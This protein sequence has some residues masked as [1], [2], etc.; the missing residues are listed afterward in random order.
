MK[1]ALIAGLAGVAVLAAASCSSESADPAPSGPA[2]VA[3]PAILQAGTLKICA[4]N[5]G[6]PPN[7]YHDESGALVGAEVDLGKALASEMGLKADFVQSAFAAVIPTLQAKQ[8]DVIMAQLYIKPE[9]AQV[10]DFV[11]YVYSGTGISVAED[12]QSGITGMDDSL[13]GKKVMVA[14]GTTAESLAQEQSD[15]CSA[16]GKPAIDINRNN[17]ADVSLQQVQNGQV[18]AYIDTAETLGYYA[19]KTGAKIQMAGA[20]FGTIKIGAATLKGNKELHDA[21]AT[22]LA[23]LESKGTYKKIL[24]EWG[25]TDLSIEK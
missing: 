3:P 11:P 13:C 17:H 25:M 4:P 5:D 14:V 22:A 8:C 24:D 10:V 20:P 23:A 2:K 9:R 12:K 6:T 15:K 21:L 19:T 7:V 16:A 1:R 18:D